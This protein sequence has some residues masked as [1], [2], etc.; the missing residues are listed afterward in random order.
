MFEVDSLQQHLQGIIPSARLEVAQL[1]ECPAFEGFC[2]L[3]VWGRLILYTV[4]HAKLSR[5]PAHEPQL[6]GL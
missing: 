5:M 1:P 2:N 4:H 3:L 6:P